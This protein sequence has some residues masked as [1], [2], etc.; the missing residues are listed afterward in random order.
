MQQNEFAYNHHVCV[1]F[2]FNF[3]FILKSRCTIVKKKQWKK[4]NLK[5]KMTQCT[6]TI[7]NGGEP[8]NETSAKLMCTIES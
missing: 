3:F 5:N 7:T 1:L 4:L 2:P 8:I 6:Y